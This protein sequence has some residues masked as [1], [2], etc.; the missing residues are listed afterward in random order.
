MG[1]EAANS[2]VGQEMDRDSLRQYVLALGVQARRFKN[3]PLLAKSRGESGT[4]TIDLEIGLGPPR[5]VL[6][7]SSG[8][9]LLD[10]E[11]LAML[12]QA[13]AHTSLPEILHG[14]NVRVSVPVRF[15]LESE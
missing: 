4:S 13:A 8:Y 7:H 6:A 12:Q 15:D 10:E 2:T 11:A 14:R 9:P 3:Y 5:V 1:Q